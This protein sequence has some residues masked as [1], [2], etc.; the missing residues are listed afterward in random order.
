V[1]LLLG[2]LLFALITAS[3]F[4]NPPP[5]DEV[6]TDWIENGNVLGETSARTCPGISF[7]DVLLDKGTR[8][9]DDYQP[10]D[11]V[12][13]ASKNIPNT[14]NL[15]LRSEVVNQLDLMVR[16]MKREKLEFKVYS[17]YRSY[18][19]QK[20]L[21]AS[22][23]KSLGKYKAQRVSAPPGHSEHQLGTTIDIQLPNSSSIYPSPAWTWLNKH[24]HEYGFVMSYP[25][26]TPE[27]E[28]EPW[29]WRYVGTPMAVQIK[30]SSQVPQ[31]FYR[32]IE[33]L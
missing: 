16:D 12:P 13:L 7:L 24:A 2:L 8:V 5:P 17:A 21:F 9:P 29:H 18:D 25:H 32:K 19:I 3:F 30:N 1:K 27:Y 22:W 10:L 31:S 11:L 4:T 28:F 15:F 6:S 20:N 26:K 33:C 23:Q 14:G